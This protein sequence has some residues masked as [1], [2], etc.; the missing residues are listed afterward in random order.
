MS[1]HNPKSKD[2]SSIVAADEREVG[3]LYS[4][5]PHPKLLAT[6]VPVLHPPHVYDRQCEKGL[7]LKAS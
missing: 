2:V 4:Q 5:L 3:G 6:Q 7:S 1:V